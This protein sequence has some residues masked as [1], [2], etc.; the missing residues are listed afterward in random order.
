MA[1]PLAA[2]GRKHYVS[3]S[4]LEA[5]LQELKETPIPE[6]GSRRT[7]KRARDLHVDVQTPLG[8]LITDIAVKLQKDE[9]EVTLPALNLPALLWHVCHD[10]PQM[11]AFFQKRMHLHPN[12]PEQA[13]S[14]TLYTD[15]IS[16][17]NQLKA[18]NTRK[19]HGFYITFDELG[20]EARTRESFWWC[21]CIARSSVVSKLKGGLSALTHA[22]ATSSIVKSLETGCMLTMASGERC[23]F[24]ARL[25]TLLGD[26]SALKFVFDVKG[27]SGTL[28]CPLCSNIISKVSAA[29]DYDATGT[30][31]SISCTSPNEFVLRTDAEIFQAH[32]LLRRR[33]GVLSKKDYTRLEQSLGLNFN[34]DGILAHRSVPLVQSLMY[35]WMHVF[36]VTGLYQIEMGL[37]LP[38]LYG[39]G[40][41]AETLLT[42]MMQLQWPQNLRGRINDTL[43]PFKKKISP[44]EFKSSASQGLNA[45]PLVRMFL[46]SLDV[47]SMDDALKLAIKSFLKLCIVLDLLLSM[48]RGETVAGRDL[49][50]AIHEH[51][52]AFKRAHGEEHITPKFHYAQHL[53]PMAQ[54]RDLI[55]CFTHERKHKEVK[56]FADHI[57]NPTK[58]FEL[59][60]MK[61]VLGRFLLDTESSTGI[62]EPHLISPKPANPLL[63]AN[64]AN[65]FGMQT[66]SQAEGAFA[67]QVAPGQIVHKGD[68]VKLK[69]GDVAE[70]WLHVRLGTGD[71]VTLL[72]PFVG[73]GRNVFQQEDANGA[74]FMPSSVIQCA[75]LYMAESPGKVRV[76]P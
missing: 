15:E 75:C 8:S 47:P 2:L 18:A 51:G 23:M 6:A 22:L 73:K 59:A 24:F 33:Q 67:A 30:L 27:A 36:L 26:E 41:S 70:V 76:V 48:N 31:R 39:A 44:N 16:P 37:L 29:E 49:E 19:V 28:P 20:P 5:L 62:M 55:S 4:A 1:N 3:Q 64:L 10:Y 50:G 9:S 25:K 63:V 46:L 38:I 7:I 13:W 57:A 52:E 61:D 53:G 42:Y 72:N 74:R 11:A 71:L 69:S 12:G 35:D 21:L 66:A 65:T 34:P 45:Y 68:M 58:G 56:N 60:I 43:Q 40:H 17:G 32:D 54:T 14:M